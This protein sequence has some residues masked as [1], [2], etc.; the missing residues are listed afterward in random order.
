MTDLLE[1][2]WAY[3]RALMAD[4]LEAMDALFAPG[5]A[6]LRGDADG[7][8]VGHDAI[9]AFRRSRGGAPPRTVLEVH[10]TPVDD[11]H[12]LVVAIT[13]PAGGGRGQQTQLWRRTDGVWQ[14][15][16]AHVAVPAPALDP[17]VWRVVGDP[18]V[19]TTVDDGPLA[20][21]TVAVKDLYAVAGHRVG[22]GNP[23]WLAEA[24]VEIAHAPVVQA[25]LDAGASLRG[26]ARTDELAYSLAGT[27]AHHGTPPNPAAPARIP[28][29]SSSG[30]ATAVALGHAGIGLGTDTGGSVRVPAAYQGL[31]GLRTTHGAISRDGLVPLAPSFDAVGWLTHTPELLARV[32][33]VLLPDA[34]PRPVPAV[35]VVPELVA[36]ARPDVAA[37]VTRHAETMGATPESWDLTDLASWRAA[38][39]TWQAWE[40]WRAHGD[41]LD[42]RLDVL[43]PDVRGRFETASRVGEAEAEEARALCA[44]AGEVVRE[45]VGDR[46]V[47]LPSASSVAPALGSDLGVVREATQLLTCLAG[48]GGLPALSVPL[49]TDDR[50]PTGACLLAAPGRDRDLLSLVSDGA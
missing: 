21:E 36:L 5:P 20:G 33:D 46:V 1:A 26:I 29:G 49:T 45:R 41:W 16:V 27:N 4:D 24:R 19:P 8:V 44:V 35:V 11:D 28:G 30:S 34:E 37:A 31:W 17:R 12:A 15:V 47:V 42:G 6:T 50:L 2:F 22:A 9:A 25:L 10:V 43:G 7:L 18:L 38:F 39:A 13:A 14:V 48:L 40:A 32:G 23:T 3:E